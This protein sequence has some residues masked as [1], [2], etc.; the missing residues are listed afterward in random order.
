MMTYGR[1]L[2]LTAVFCGL[3]ACGGRANQASTVCETAIAERLTG[4]QYSVDHGALAASAEEQ[5]D[6]V[7]VLQSPIVFKQGLPGEY[8]Q[9]VDCKVR[10]GDGEPSLI[11]LAFVY[12]TPPTGP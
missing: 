4:Q 6:G 5:A 12:I 9:T 10:F 11:S 3:A 1:G 7:V 8:T 2:A